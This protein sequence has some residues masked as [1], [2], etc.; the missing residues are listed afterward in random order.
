MAKIKA[1]KMFLELS[2]IHFLL[3]EIKQ[4]YIRLEDGYIFDRYHDIILTQYNCADETYKELVWM[5]NNNTI[6]IEY[7]E[8]QHFDFVHTAQYVTKLVDI[9]IELNKLPEPIYA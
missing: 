2:S 4:Q 1:S 8:E 7:L 6:T 5:F 3:E 9:S